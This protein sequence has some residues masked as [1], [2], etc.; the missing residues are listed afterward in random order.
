MSECHR[1]LAF[2]HDDIASA[3][4]WLTDEGDKLRN[5]KLV[6]YCSMTTLAQR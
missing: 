2:C 1:A 3:A 4:Q 6:Q 5:R